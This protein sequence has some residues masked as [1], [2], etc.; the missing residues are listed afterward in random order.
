MHE[1]MRADR[2]FWDNYHKLKKQGF[3]DCPDKF[4]E[5]RIFECNN[6]SF[7]LFYNYV[8]AGR[9]GVLPANCWW[10]KSH[11]WQNGY[12]FKITLSDRY[13]EMTPDDIVKDDNLIS[14]LAETVNRMRQKSKESEKN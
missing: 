2:D 4:R 1:T 11:N 8:A 13:N 14:Y 9:I 10:V 7:K 12:R 5:T 3:E 6:E